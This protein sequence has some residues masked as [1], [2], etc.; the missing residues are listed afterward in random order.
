MAHRMLVV[1]ASP[2]AAPA[3]LAPG[4]DDR[5]LSLLV[6]DGSARRRGR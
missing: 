4:G 1:I 3:R 2:D 6:R 5:G